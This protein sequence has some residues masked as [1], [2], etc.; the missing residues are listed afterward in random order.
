MKT[1]LI[2]LIAFFAIITG[3]VCGKNRKDYEQRVM[4][5]VEKDRLTLKDLGKPALTNPEAST[6]ILLGDTQTYT[7]KMC[8]QPVLEMMTAWI[9]YNIK[10]LN[11]KALLHTGDIVEYN[12]R[13]DHGSAFDQNSKQQWEWV[14][15]CFKRLDNKLPCILIPGNHD[16]SNN[17]FSGEESRN[18]S[19]FSK[20]FDP[21]RNYKTQEA[22]YRVFTEKHKHQTIDNVIY[23]IDVGGKWGEVYVVALELNPRKEVIDWVLKRLESK[24]LKDKLAILLTHSYLAPNAVMPKDAKFLW[25]NLVKKAPQIRLVLSGHY[26]EFYGSFKGHSAVRSDVNDVGKNVYSILFDPQCTYGGWNGSGGDGW[27]RLLEFQPDGKTIKVRT[28]SVLYGHS[29]MTKHLAW[30]TAPYDMFEFTLDK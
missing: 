10:P 19:Q 28:Y 22:I 4:E 16:Y 13:V 14:S 20:Y 18:T 3:S 12:A 24:R 5:T 6:M 26:A 27:L 15:H 2:F 7:P 11:I 9:A 21:S 29:P 8:N 17:W 25:E 1:K 30:R 23:K